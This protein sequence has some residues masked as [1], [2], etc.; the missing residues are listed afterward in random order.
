MSIRLP[1]IATSFHRL[2]LPGA[3]FPR[4]WWPD[5]RAEGAF[6]GSDRDPN[7]QVHLFEE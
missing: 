4:S 2:F 3:G 6:A 5:A 1:M 7:A